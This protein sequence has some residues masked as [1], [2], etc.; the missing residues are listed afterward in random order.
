M[1]SVFHV[2]LLSTALALTGCSDNTQV[3]SSSAA[4]TTKQSSVGS[5]G[6]YKVGNPYQVA[7]VWY[8]PKEDYSYKEIGVSS[9]YGQDF[10]N[11][12]TANGELYDMHALTAAHRTLPLPSIVRV[13]NLQNGRSL[14]LRVNDRGPFV[15]NRVIDVS[16]RAAQLLG[17]KEQGT[18]Q[19]QVEILPEESKKLKEEMLAMAEG[20]AGAM[21]VALNGAVYAQE[22]VTAPQNLGYPSNYPRLANPPPA[23]NNPAVAPLVAASAGTKESPYNDWDD[24]L[25]KAQAQKTA[26]EAP[27]APQKQETPKPAPAKASA[28][29]PKAAEVSVIVAPGYYVQVGAFGN[30]DNAE[31]MRAKAARFGSAVIQPVTTAGKTLYRVRLGPENAKKALEIMDKV[32]NNGFS[33]AR[34]VEEKGNSAAGQRLDSA[35]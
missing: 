17:F 1:R 35:F 7:G 12:I 26:Y 28:P 15:N 6:Y 10:H 18:T 19:V 16:M 13:T 25:P 27:A 9:W 11:G 32:S 21:P 22:E 4:G 31:K 33:D 34:L 23:A 29:K 2:L 5:A 30:I 3:F 24:D 20:T 8:Y 14:V